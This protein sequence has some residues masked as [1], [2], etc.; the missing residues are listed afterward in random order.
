MQIHP[1]VGLLYSHTA[2]TPITLFVFFLV[3]FF[4]CVYFLMNVRSYLTTLLIRN[5]AKLA[6]LDRARDC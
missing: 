5:D 4:L 3:L 2:S 6:Q 1:G